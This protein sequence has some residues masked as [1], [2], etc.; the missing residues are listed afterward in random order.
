M[1][2]AAAAP[3][4]NTAYSRY[5]TK[6]EPNHR[7]AAQEREALDAVE[8]IS[9][10]TGWE[11]VA[12]EKG[13]EITPKD[14]PGRP[15][16]ILRGIGIIE[17]FSPIE[18]YGA[19]QLP[20][21]RVVCAHFHLCLIPSNF[22][23]GDPLFE[24]GRAVSM[25]GPRSI[26]SYASSKG[27]WP[28]SGRDF[29]LV[30]GTRTREDGTIIGAGCA[31]E[32]PLVP[33]VSGKVRGEIKLNGWLIEPLSDNRGVRV[34][35]VN[36]IDLKGSIPGSIIKMVANKIPLC[37]YSIR[38]YLL[39][40]GPPPYPVLMGGLLRAT[41]DFDH[42]SSR[43]TLDFDVDDSLGGETHVFVSDKRYK[44]GYTGTL[45]AGTLRKGTCHTGGATDM[46]AL[47]AWARAFWTTAFWCWST[48]PWVASA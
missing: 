25:L 4:A 2:T 11:V 33:T 10:E 43:F 32:D 27:Q 20:G 47:Q 16:G 36:D 22:F 18:F 30:L 42:E 1:E 40:H 34:V 13:V 14:V 23:V 21:C 44:S 6:E 15:L 19:S 26:L 46:G 24:S 37:V 31:V 39:Q 12:D 5:A 17:G 29:C 3:S 38:K 48:R 41:P 9:R 28:T 7:Y 45:S 35:N 8:R